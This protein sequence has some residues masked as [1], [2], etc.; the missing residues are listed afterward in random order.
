MKKITS[1]QQ[2]SVAA[3]VRLVSSSDTPWGKAQSAEQVGPGIISYSTASHG[4]YFLY[5]ATN[6]KVPSILKK[7]TC[8][9]LGLKGWY[10]E[11][12]DWAIIVF[13]FKQYFEEDHYKA[14]L[15]TLERHHTDAWQKLKKES[16]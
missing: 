10:E 1:K 13:I 12:C 9:E 7:S 6:A 15:V 5:P 2:K 8:G 14:A 4:G 3:D 16:K 11:D